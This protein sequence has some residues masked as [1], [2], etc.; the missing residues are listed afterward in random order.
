MLAQFINKLKILHS[1]SK[2]G[3]AL[4]ASFALLF[5]LFLALA[6]VL[7]AKVEGDH[8]ERDIVHGIGVDRAGDCEV[9]SSKAILVSWS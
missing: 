4:D 3:I 2:R 9:C 1:F 8:H 7:G 6:L 5:T